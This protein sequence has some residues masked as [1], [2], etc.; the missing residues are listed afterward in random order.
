VYSSHL[1]VFFPTLRPSVVSPA[2]DLLLVLSSNFSHPICPSTK[3]KKPGELTQRHRKSGEKKNE[4]R[5]RRCD[6]KAKEGKRARKENQ[7]G[8]TRKGE[9]TGMEKIMGEKKESEGEKG[10]IGR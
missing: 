10:N 7:N 4:D 3:K 9:N 6:K 5:D 8:R 2:T 1:A